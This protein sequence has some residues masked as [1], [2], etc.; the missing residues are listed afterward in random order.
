MG[1]E[2]L[3]SLDSLKPCATSLLSRRSRCTAR[4]GVTLNSPSYCPDSSPARQIVSRFSPSGFPRECMSKTTALGQPR[5]ALIPLRRTHCAPT[6]HMSVPKLR[7]SRGP[8]RCHGDRP[9]LSL[10]GG[11]QAWGIPARPTPREF[12][13]PAFRLPVT[14]FDG[15]FGLRQM[16]PD[17]C[18]IDRDS[19]DLRTMS[20]SQHS[21]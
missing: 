4:T 15:G 2:I 13:K 6:D 8:C 12:R 18:L 11:R 20:S 10:A 16:S 21:F 19:I 17:R 7:D 3:P 1:R 14:C 9:Q 5:P